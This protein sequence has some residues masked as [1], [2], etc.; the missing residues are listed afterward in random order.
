MEKEMQKDRRKKM[1]VL[2]EM[3]MRNKLKEVLR[4]QRKTDQ[5]LL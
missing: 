4:K 5:F 1:K 3:K 2:K